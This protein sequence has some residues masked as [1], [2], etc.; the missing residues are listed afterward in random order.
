MLAPFIYLT[1]AIPSTSKECLLTLTPG[2]L[3]FVQIEPRTS[4]EGYTL[5]ENNSSYFVDP[6]LSGEFWKCPFRPAVILSANKKREGR[7]AFFLVPLTTSP[8]EGA[9]SLKEID[10]SLPSSLSNLSAYVFPRAIEIL[11]LPSQVSIQISFDAA[12]L[13]RESDR[14][15]CYHH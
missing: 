15:R 4:V 3:V 13:T 1:G 8:L 11:C 12:T 2:D 5:A 14:H 10:I 9:I 7:Y 6:T